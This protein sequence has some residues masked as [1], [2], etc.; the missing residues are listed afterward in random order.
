MTVSRKPRP[1]RGATS[2]TARQKENKMERTYNRDPY[3]EL[4][5]AVPTADGNLR[6]KTIRFHGAD[7]KAENIRKCKEYGY[8]V[9]GCDKLYPFSMLRNGHNIE[10]AYNNQHIICWEMEQGE[11]PWNDEAF[12]C[13]ADISEVY[14]HAIGSAIYWCNGKEYAKLR[15]WS[16]WAECHRAEANARAR[17]ERAEA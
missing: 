8:T 11:R 3:F 5:Y 9:L 2:R 4:K 14:G 6:E 13:L 10:L 15:D 16:E 12:E 1:P 17:A 7:K